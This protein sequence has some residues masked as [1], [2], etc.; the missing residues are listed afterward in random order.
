MNNVEDFREKIKKDFEKQRNDKRFLQKKE[1]QLLDRK[2]EEKKAIFN[3]NKY[4]LERKIEDGEREEDI[5]KLR[6]YVTNLRK[7]VKILKANKRD[8]KVVHKLQLAEINRLEGETLAAEE[9]RIAFEKEAYGS[10]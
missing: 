2:I 4:L 1:V 9:K 5:E 6:E 7:H 3:A 10:V 8:L